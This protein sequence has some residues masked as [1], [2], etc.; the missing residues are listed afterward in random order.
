ML[1][2]I[3]WGALHIC[4]VKNFFWPKKEWFFD[5][6][7]QKHCF[8]TN[9]GIFS[10]NYVI[11]MLWE[12]FW[13]ALHICRSKLAMLKIHSSCVTFLSLRNLKAAPEEASYATQEADQE[14]KW[15]LRT[16]S[17]WKI[18]V[19]E[20]LGPQSWDT[21]GG[22]APPPPG[23]VCASKSPHLIGLRPA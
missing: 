18:W 20:F 19:L 2:E 12:I 1:W 3:F 4:G 10:F 17:V 5:K 11:S 14:L 22:S 23:T 16:L 8:L 6:N 9:I 13:G 15:N 21:R 7:G